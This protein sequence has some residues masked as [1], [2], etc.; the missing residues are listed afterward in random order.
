MKK[1][2]CLILPFV[3]ILLFAGCSFEEKTMI[4]TQTSPDGGYTVSL[5]QVG[6]PKWSFGPVKAVL[7]LE[8]ESGKVIDKENISLANDGT[9]V[10]KD[11]IVEIVWCDNHV[12][13]EMREFD[14]T[15]RYTYSLGYDE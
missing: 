12:E 11:N 6:A 3:L 9:D 1:L 8:D 13:I 5:F 14:T 10:H 7:V 2:I 15:S 4:A